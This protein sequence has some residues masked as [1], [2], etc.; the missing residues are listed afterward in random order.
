MRVEFTD[1]VTHGARG[2]FV[3]G[4]CVKPQLAHGI[5][6]APLHRLK[7]VADVRQS[8]VENHVHGVIEVRFFRV[9]LKGYLFVGVGRYYEVG[10]EK[11]C[12]SL[13]SIKSV[14]STPI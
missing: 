10:H 2:L 1:D 6:N 13:K 11:S 4:G 5:N 8:P 12:S 3:F 9:L 7:T 14:M